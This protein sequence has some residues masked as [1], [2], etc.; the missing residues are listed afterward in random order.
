MPLVGA[1]NGCVWVSWWNTTS[2]VKALAGKVP[3]CGSVPVPLKLTFV[4]AA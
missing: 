3:S 2:Q 4:P 1:K